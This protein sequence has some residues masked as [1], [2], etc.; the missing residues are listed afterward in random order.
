MLCGNELWKTFSRPYVS[1]L[2]RI[3]RA[4]HLNEFVRYFREE[5]TM[6][7]SSLQLT[8]ALALVA[9][10]VHNVA[11]SYFLIIDLQSEIL[12]SIFFLHALFCSKLSI[13][14]KKKDAKLNCYRCRDIE[15]PRFS[16]ALS[17]RTL[18]LHQMQRYHFIFLLLFSIGTRESIH[19]V[20]FTKTTKIYRT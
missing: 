19:T 7:A 18:I 3:C 11:C 2:N 17:I 13:N 9:I 6:G 10:L 20:L 15:V 4:I 1:R 8:Y 14:S 5:M 12:V 16:Y